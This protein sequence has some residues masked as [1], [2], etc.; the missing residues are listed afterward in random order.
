M[1]WNFLFR[2]TES[3]E[4]II[5][6]PKFVEVFLKRTPLE[7]LSATQ[8]YSYGVSCKPWTYH[9]QSPLIGI[10][11]PSRALFVPMSLIGCLF[12]FLLKDR[13]LFINLHKN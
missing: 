8:D 4:C 3:A 6:D 11:Y 5:Y 7:I 9:G 10:L 13:S 2:P 1:S 12:A